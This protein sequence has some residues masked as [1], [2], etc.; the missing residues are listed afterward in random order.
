MK[1][2]FNKKLILSILSILC[3]LTLFGCTSKVKEEVK[4]GTD[5][6][7]GTNVEISYTDAFSIVDYGNDIKL[8]TD[9]ENQKFLLVPEGEET[10]EIAEA[11]GAEVIHT[12]LK[13][14]VYC[15]ST[16]VS[17]LKPFFEE[18]DW[19]SISGVTTKA[20]KWYIDEVKTG[21]EKG[22][23]TFVGGDGMGEPD[24]ELIQSLNPDMVVV[25]TGENGQ[26]TTLAKMKELGIPCMVVNDYTEN[27]DMGRL[28]WTRFLATFYNKDKEAAQFMSEKEDMLKEIQAHVADKPSPKV[29]WASVYEGTVY[30]PNG[31]S[32]VA[33]QIEKAGGDYVFADLNQDKGSS[34]QLTLEEFYE[35]AK[36]A[37]VFIYSTSNLYMPSIADLK[38]VSPLLKDFKSIKDENVYCFTP[39][40]YMNLDKTVEGVKDLAK[41]FHEDVYTD[42]QLQMYEKLP[43][44]K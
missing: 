7:K 29:V 13:N 39:S 1:K 24:F 36:D 41:I 17:L 18:E 35:K 6:L 11:S 31:G 2:I 44:Q 27:D 19:N 23:I 9:G 26:Q 25:Y 12:P 3:V 14:V 28:E 8:V 32:Y 30:V 10:P 22:D 42:W 4:T 43:V 20:E 34:T 37:D 33:N 15:S 5:P 38:A 40:Y 16:Q 21:M